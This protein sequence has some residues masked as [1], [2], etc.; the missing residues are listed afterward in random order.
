VTVNSEVPSIHLALQHALLGK[1]ILRY[2][3]IHYNG[4]K[5]KGVPFIWRDV[6]QA[7]FEIL[8]QAL[9]EAPVLQIPDFDKEFVLVTDA[10]DLA[11]SAILHQRLGEGLAPI[12]Y[13][14]RLLT[15]AEKGYSMYEKECLA[16]KFPKRTVPL[17]GSPC[18]WFILPWGHIRKRM[19]I[20]WTS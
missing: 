11:V 10:S 5:K 7:A 8:K 1:P 20:V 16:V 9:C 19:S 17:C 2:H 6:H 18:L 14:S 15:A 3:P 13:Y 12:S 4:L